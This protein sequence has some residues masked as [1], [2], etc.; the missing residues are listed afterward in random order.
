MGFM[1]IPSLLFDKRIKLDYI[2]KI[3]SKVL[4]IEGVFNEY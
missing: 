3:F 4:G 2:Y 1:I